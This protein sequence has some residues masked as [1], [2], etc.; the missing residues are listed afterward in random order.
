MS[1]K[2]FL[3]LIAQRHQA[4]AVRQIKS[5]LLLPPR[6]PQ[7]HHLNLMVF[8]VDPRAALIVLELACH[9]RDLLRMDRSLRQEKYQAAL[10]ARPR[11]ESNAVRQPPHFHRTVPPFLKCR[12]KLS[13]PRHGPTITYQVKSFDIIPSN[14][15]RDSR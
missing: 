2:Q 12:A 7:D 1:G 8:L 5:R 15:S 11:N 3:S 14:A 10:T 4:G 6:I 13:A 9:I